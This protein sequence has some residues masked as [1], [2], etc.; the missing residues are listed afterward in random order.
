MTISHVAL[1]LLILF[2]GLIKIRI[3]KGTQS[4]VLKDSLSDK[5]FLGKA[6]EAYERDAA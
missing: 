4:A 5:F 2:L 3:T 1:K 6:K